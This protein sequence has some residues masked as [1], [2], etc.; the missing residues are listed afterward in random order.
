MNEY[1][2]ERTQPTVYLDDGGRPI[3]GFIVTVRLTEYN[4]IHEIHVPDLGLETVGG[5]IETLLAQRQALAV[6]GAE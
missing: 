3:R 2:I 1:K 4:E 5:S 6:L